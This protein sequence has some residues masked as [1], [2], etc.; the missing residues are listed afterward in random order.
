MIY[1]IPSLH[2][3]AVAMNMQLSMNSA[4]TVCLSGNGEIDELFPHAYYVLT[5]YIALAG[6]SPLHQRLLTRP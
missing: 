2:I 1:E 4:S 3:D 6:A 5:Y